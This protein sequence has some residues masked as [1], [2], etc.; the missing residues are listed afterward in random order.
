MWVK[1]LPVN[2]GDVD[3]LKQ[4]IIAILK[5]ESLRLR[6]IQGGYETI[7]SRFRN[8]TYQK[9]LENVYDTLLGIAE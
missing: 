6:I 4:S 3:N 5:D 7:N 8:E 9:K 1:S 2:Y